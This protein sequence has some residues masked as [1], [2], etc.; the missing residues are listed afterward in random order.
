MGLLSKLFCKEEP[1]TAPVSPDPVTEEPYRPFGTPKS[2]QIATCAGCGAQKEVPSRYQVLPWRLVSVRV[3][4]KD[5]YDNIVVCP[6]CI[7][8]WAAAEEKR[9]RQYA[10]AS[11]PFKA[12]HAAAQAYLQNWLRE[13]PR[14]DFKNYPTRETWIRRITCGCCGRTEEAE[15]PAHRTPGPFDWPQVWGRYC[16][17]KVCPECYALPE[18]AEM[19]AHREAYEARKDRTVGD[20]FRKANSLK[21]D[22]TYPD[23]PSGWRMTDRIK[24]SFSL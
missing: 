17:S 8:V 11:R 10:L 18:H 24:R 22:W 21:P 1:T 7:P 5:K 3:S 12:A 16:G 19:R 23:L 6:D 4:D 15:C 20:R 9:D 2:S 13:N 14:P